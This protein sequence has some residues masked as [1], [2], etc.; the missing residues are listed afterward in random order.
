MLEQYSESVSNLPVERMLNG[1]SVNTFRMM[2]GN[3]D[4]NMGE[5]CAAAL[6]IGAISCCYRCY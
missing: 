4:G 3:V 1:Y 6:L 5:I 2:V